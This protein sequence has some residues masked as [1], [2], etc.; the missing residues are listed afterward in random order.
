MAQALYMQAAEYI[1]EKIAAG[2]YP[3]GSQIPTENELAL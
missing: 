2:E 3:V 1:R